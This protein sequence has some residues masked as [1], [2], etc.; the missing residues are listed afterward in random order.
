MEFP[1]KLRAALG[2]GPALGSSKADCIGRELVGCATART[3]IWLRVVRTIGACCSDPR[4]GGCPRSAADSLPTFRLRHAYQRL[5]RRLLLMSGNA[6]R[7]SMHD[8]RPIG[9]WRPLCYVATCE[10]GPTWNRIAYAENTIANLS[11]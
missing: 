6:D 7:D 4:S 9:T 3:T 8:E 11:A 1:E 10:V 5:S 2:T